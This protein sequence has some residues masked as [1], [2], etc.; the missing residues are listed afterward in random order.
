[1]SR[2]GLGVPEEQW[3]LKDY[4]SFIVDPHGPG[5]PIHMSTHCDMRD[6]RPSA[7]ELRLGDSVSRATW[8]EGDTCTIPL[9]HRDV[10]YLGVRIRTWRLTLF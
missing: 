6:E 3:F 2:G 10:I 1:M 5:D 8:I 7:C 9:D 4:R